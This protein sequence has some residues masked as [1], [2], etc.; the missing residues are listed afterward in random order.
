MTN[1][2]ALGDSLTAGLGL[3]EEQAYPAVVGSLLAAEGFDIVQARAEI[4]VPA[5]PR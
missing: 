3:E 1:Y 4:A 5:E 2:V